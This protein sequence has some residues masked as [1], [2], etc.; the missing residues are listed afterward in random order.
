M[1]RHLGGIPVNRLAGHHI[2][3]ALL[4]EFQANEKLALGLAPEGTTKKVDYW[5]PGFYY[6]ARLAHVPIVCGFIDYRRKAV[7]VGPGMVP[8]G[9]LEADMQFFHDFYL[10]VTGRHPERAAPI[11]VLRTEVPSS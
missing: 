5:K 7:G 3:K 8:S 11:R 2:V 1:F 6:I 10:H 4:H 9:N